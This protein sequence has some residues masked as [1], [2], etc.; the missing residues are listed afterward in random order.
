MIN[1]KLL[2]ALLLAALTIAGC[3]SEPAA[4]GSTAAE[5]SGTESTETDLVWAINVG[6]PAYEG[7]DGTQYR[8]EESISGGAVGTMETVK[9]SQDPFLYKSFRE[10][11]R[12]SHAPAGER[13]LRHHVSFCRA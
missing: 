8:A 10:G 7:I 6:G 5:A 12:R 1:T 9:G 3:Q 11:E 4:S 13:L 2:P